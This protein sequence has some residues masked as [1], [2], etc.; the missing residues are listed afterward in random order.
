MLTAAEIS[1]FLRNNTNTF[2]F[3]FALAAA[4]ARTSMI[5]ITAEQHS[6]NEGLCAS[7]QRALRWLLQ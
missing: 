1:F 6:N 5:T 7:S 3:A 2:S 4:P